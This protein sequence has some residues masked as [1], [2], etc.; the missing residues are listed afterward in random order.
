MENENNASYKTEITVV[1]PNLNGIRYL[2][3][4][5]SSLK[6]QTFKKFDVII[7]DNGSTDGSVDLIKE[8][9]RWARLI[10]FSENTGFAKACNTGIKA[11]RGEYAVILNND[12]EVMP[13]WLEELYRVI[14]K[15]KKIGMVASKIYLNMET[16]EIDSVGMIIFLDG[17]GRQ[18]G[19][20]EIDIGQF[21]NEEEI[22]FAHGCAAMC[23]IEMLN[24]I[25]LLDEDFFAYAEDT[26]LGLRS[27]L[28]GW[29]VVTAPKAVVYHKYSATAGKYTSLKAMLVERNRIF[30]TIKNY[31]FTLLCMVP[32]FTLWRFI[33][34]L[35]GIIINKG[36][37]ARFK[38]TYSTK[39]I[40]VTVLSAYLSALRYLPLMF[41]KRRDVKRNISGSEIIKIIMKNRISA[42][43]LILR[44]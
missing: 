22:L 10:E 42:S 32:F 39:E 6:N 7:V 12:T 11:S 38:E 5:L 13:T 34:Q 14:E 33:V 15:D 23:R 41:K 9:Y 28:A 40:V 25:G 16:R 43:E 31:P 2:P 19:R 17:I 29:K 35:Y 3:K 30:V 27:W 26:D 21:D 1:I 8:D 36:N 37:T 20:G 44:D 4:C 18:R 24:E